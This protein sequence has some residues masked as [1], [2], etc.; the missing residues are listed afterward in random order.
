MR[1]FIADD[2]VE[3]R[4]RLAA[5]LAGIRGLDVIGMSGDVQG[6]IEAIRRLRPDTAIL[7]I[8]MPGG[9]GL[10]VLAAVKQAKPA[11]IVI[12]LTVGSRSEYQ[13]KCCAAGAD[14]FFEKSSDLRKMILMLTRL[15]GKPPA[16]RKMCHSS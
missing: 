12:M 6:A 10:D 7:D 15:A 2:N 8:R 5:I 13:A 4:K 1:L 9:S 14:Y 16:G 3:F 11:P